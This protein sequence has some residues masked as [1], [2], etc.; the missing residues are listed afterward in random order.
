MEGSSNTDPFLIQYI[1]TEPLYLV[2]AIGEVLNEKRK[3]FFIEKY[4]L[5]K[6]NNVSS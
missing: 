5:L 1:S 4:T 6:Y 3:E 2:Y